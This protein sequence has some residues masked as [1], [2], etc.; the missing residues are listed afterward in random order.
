MTNTNSLRL[1]Y[2]GILVLSLRRVSRLHRLLIF[3]YVFNTCRVNQ[4]KSILG[5]LGKI[6]PP[7]KRKLLNATFQW[8]CWGWRSGE[9]TRLHSISPGVKI[10]A[11]TRYVGWICYSFSPLL[12]E[13]FLRV[14]S[15]SFSLV[16]RSGAATRL[17]LAIKRITNRM[18]ETKYQE[19]VIN[20]QL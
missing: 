17:T 4:Q 20:G 1:P 11:R 3:K 15:V 14:Y 13:V 18:I 12:R 16:W 19:R 10:P 8:C 2:C 9:S 6:A 7:F 5:S